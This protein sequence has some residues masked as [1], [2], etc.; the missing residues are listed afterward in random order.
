MAGADGTI[1]PSGTGPTGAAL[2]ADGTT[3]PAGSAGPTGAAVQRYNRT[4]GAQ[5]QQGG[6]GNGTTDHRKCRTNRAELATVPGTQKR[7]QQSGSVTVLR[8]QRD[9]GG[10]YCG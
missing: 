8:D 2:G 6:G 1:G 10:G 7:D 9:S 3:G 4:S 5:D